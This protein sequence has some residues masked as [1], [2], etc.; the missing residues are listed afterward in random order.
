MVF[1]MIFEMALA[2]VAL[3]V[4][5]LSTL[6]MVLGMAPAVDWAA[7]QSF[8]QWA[9]CWNERECFPQWIRSMD[10][11]WL[12]WQLYAVLIATGCKFSLLRV[13]AIALQVFL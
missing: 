2:R 7:L 3:D 13:F 9:G 11:T 5:I 12:L 6:V 10:G 1:V 4:C 8:L